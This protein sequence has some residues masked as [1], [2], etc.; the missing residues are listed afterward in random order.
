MKL[1][2]GSCE[3]AKKAPVLGHMPRSQLDVTHCSYE[4]DVT[5]LL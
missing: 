1:G 3:K 2:G 4:F 5:V